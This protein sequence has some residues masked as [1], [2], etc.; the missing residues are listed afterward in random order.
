MGLGTAGCVAAGPLDQRANSLAHSLKKSGH[1]LRPYLGAI[2]DWGLVHVPG[3]EA[4]LD[5]G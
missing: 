2:R 4:R 1:N 5:P 3:T